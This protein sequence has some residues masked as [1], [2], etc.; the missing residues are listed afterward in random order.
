MLGL[1]GL[2]EC[3]GFHILKL[4]L[5]LLNRDF[6]LFFGVFQILIVFFDFLYF[7]SFHSTL[8]F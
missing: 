1:F 4:L 7:N 8:G 6:E 5:K 3:A 2:D